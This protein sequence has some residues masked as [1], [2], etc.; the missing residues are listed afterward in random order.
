MA[1]CYE[2]GY[3]GG[4]GDCPKCES[5]N[6]RGLKRGTL[7]GNLIGLGNTAM[8]LAEINSLGHKAYAEKK[9]QESKE[10]KKQ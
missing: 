6:Q 4:P 8:E 10:E 7:T 3:S 1:D 9:R 5:E 2:H